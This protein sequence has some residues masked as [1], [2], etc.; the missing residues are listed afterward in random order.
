[1][2]AG[3]S[4]YARPDGLD[5][6]AARQEPQAPP[7]RNP[8]HRA[9][10]ARADRGLRLRAALRLCDRALPARSA[11]AATGRRRAYRRVPPRRARADRGGGRMS[12]VVEV[13]GLKKHFALKRG[14][15]ARTSAIVKAVDGVS[16]SIAPGETLC[17]VG[18]SGCGK[19]TVGKLVLRLLEP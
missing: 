2:P 15:L 8:R 4:L 16:F 5:P 19:S 17:L 12:A 6:A 11:R 7:R 10:A 3:A 14:L 18:E 13:E 9:L 1:R